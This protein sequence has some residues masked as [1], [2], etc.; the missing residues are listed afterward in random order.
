MKFGKTIHDWN[1]AKGDSTLRLQYNL[2]PS[3]TVID[4]GSFKGEWLKNI[5]NLYSCNIF[6]YEPTLEGF[7]TIKNLQTE[8]IIIK[9]YGLFN[10]R[11]KIKISNNGNASS[12]VT[13]NGTEEI[14]V[15]NV[16]EEMPLWGNVDLIKI[17]IEGAEYELLEALIENSSLEKFKNL[18]IQFHKFDFIRE[19]S[20]RRQ[21]I[22]ESL[23]KTHHL[24]YDF[25]FIWENWEIN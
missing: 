21:K 6:A 19:P 17:N 23:S 10:E 14:E 12:I 18:Q 22:R 25:E 15:L 9:K 8:K 5:I 24:T 2:T 13:S 7:E 4:V 20:E 11:K 16:I 1:N 3:S